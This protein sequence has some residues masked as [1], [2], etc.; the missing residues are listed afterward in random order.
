MPEP[1]LENI[2]FA[3]PEGS[4]TAIIGPT[5]SGK[6]TLINLLLGLWHPDGGEIF[7]NHTN[8]RNVNLEQFRSKLRLVGQDSYIFN[9]SLRENLL[10]ANP[11]ATDEELTEALDKVG[12]STFAHSLDMEPGTHGMRFSGGERQHFSLA[13]VLLKNQMFGYLMN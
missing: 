6:S 4:K 2:S 8:L 5:G 3:I 12:L 9:R 11:E 1:T 10:I 7:V 13:R